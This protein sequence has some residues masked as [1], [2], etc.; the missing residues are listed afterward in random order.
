MGA[1]PGDRRPRFGGAFCCSHASFAETIVWVTRDGEDDPSMLQRIALF[2]L[3]MGPEATPSMNA[4]WRH[5][6]NGIAGARNQTMILAALA[7][8]LAWIV[9]ALLRAIFG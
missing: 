4:F 6:R 2:E 9:T 5:I 7:T 8:F 1:S 3:Q